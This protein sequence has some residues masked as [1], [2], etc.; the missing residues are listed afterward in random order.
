VEDK[1]S[2]SYIVMANKPA[3]PDSLHPLQCGYVGVL[4]VELY[5]SEGYDLEAATDAFTGKYREIDAGDFV[6]TATDP[7]H[8][9]DF[10]YYVMNC[11]FAKAKNFAKKWIS[12]RGGTV[13]I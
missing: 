13:T 11:S 2:K 4:N 8:E 7:A 5:R 10:T 12:E 3:I 9:A 6:F 1:K